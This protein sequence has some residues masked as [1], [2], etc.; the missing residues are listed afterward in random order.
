MKIEN[1]NN[2]VPQI[3]I[4]DLLP[5]DCFTAKWEVLGCILKQTTTLP[6]GEGR[7]WYTSLSDNKL[8]YLLD[9]SETLVTPVNAKVVIC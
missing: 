5:G 6:T 7:I 4:D 9:K 3:L 2:K 1:N 8:E